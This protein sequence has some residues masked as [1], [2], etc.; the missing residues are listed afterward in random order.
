MRSSALL[1]LAALGWSPRG[2]AAQEEAWN[3]GRVL[4]L[5]ERARAKRQ[6]PLHDSTLAGYR[7]S[8]RG[9]VYFYLDPEMGLDPVLLRAD[10]VALELH[11]A[12]PDR[13]RQDIVG[14][15]S[16]EQLPIRNFQYFLDRLTVVQN[17]FG[18][19]I[20]V[21]EGN[22][23]A[24]VLHPLAP[25]AEQLYEYR[26]A[27]SLTLRLPSAPA[28]IQAYEVA[29]RPRDPS[30]PALVGSIFIDRATADLVR[31]GFTFTPV[32]YV[33]RR[34]DRIRIELEH[35]LWEGRYWLPYEQRIEVRRELPELDLGVGTVIRGV[36]RVRDY[37]FDVVHPPNFF[38]GPP[39][40]FA[41]PARRA[42]H[43]FDEG[44]LD[45][46]ERDGIPAA[47]GPEALADLLGGIDRAALLR[48]RYAATGLPRVR[49]Y[50]P[51][52]SS[53]VRYGRA[54]GLALGGGIAVRAGPAR[55][56]LL[57]GY[58]FSAEKV[59]GTV[60]AT[61]PAQPL[62]PRLEVYA[63]KLRD[64]GP[65]PA[66]PGI[67]NSVA[68]A[69]GTDDLDPFHAAGATLDARLSSA[70]GGLVAAVTV[71]RQ[72]AASLS[73]DDAP[74]GDRPFRRVLPAQDGTRASFALRLLPSAGLQTGLRIRAGA[75][76]EAGAWRG[77]EFGEVMAEGEMSFLADGLDAEVA[78]RGTAG[79]RAGATAPQHRHFLG[80]RPTL[81]GHPHR[82]WA[83]RRFVLVEAEAVRHLVR[84]WLGVRAFAAA[85]NV[86]GGVGDSADDPA[87][88]GWAERASGW[89]ASAGAGVSLFHDLLRVDAAHGF[90]ART[91]LMVSLSPGI[92]ARF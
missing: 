28:P 27:D 78:L 34:V 31:M 66:G 55:L 88:D 64:V 87:F 35:A 29:V 30:L 22:D 40:R 83:G 16:Q 45:A 51:S 76:V 70:G 84:G 21:G 3:S 7:A 19:V 72:T 24:A 9:H 56:N 53:V 25:G 20:E 91:Q 73:V 47:T 59:H 62:R 71:E 67:V 77:A 57:G 26:I 33:D 46:L 2:A 79:A 42:E 8:A 41:P 11:W 54:E 61:L 13:T 82:A 50:V 74:L 12:P 38:L 75:Q 18:D 5:V 17:G 48:A 85:G 69:F 15:R 60:E 23:V 65:R 52:V 39:V 44:L 58:A 63:G 81:P 6:A 4:D 37:D 43:V 49:F 80:G 10:Q 68:A 86:G 1:L 90:G 14:L 36:L 92:A 89:R 32:S